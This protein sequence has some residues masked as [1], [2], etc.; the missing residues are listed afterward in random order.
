MQ[1][2]PAGEVD[3]QDTASPL[4]AAHEF[5]NA[6]LGVLYKIL[7]VVGAGEP[8]GRPLVF[9]VPTRALSAAVGVI[10]LDNA[11]VTKVTDK[12]IVKK[13]IL[14]IVSFKFIS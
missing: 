14:F 1:V 2:D 10:A 4:R 9:P 12:T 11:E 13:Y 8:I 7:F 6:P 5:Q 3:G